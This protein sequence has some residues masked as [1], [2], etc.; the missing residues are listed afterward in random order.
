MAI[1]MLLRIC[2]GSWSVCELLEGVFEGKDY[3][4]VNVVVYDVSLLEELEGKIIL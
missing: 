1:V 3:L 2:N 4:I